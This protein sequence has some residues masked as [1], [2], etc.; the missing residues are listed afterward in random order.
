L[1][2]FASALVAYNAFAIT[3]GAVA[4]EHGRDESELL[5]HYY[6]ALEISEATDGM[7]VAIPEAR[8]DELELHSDEE[9]AAEVRTIF[10][11][12]DLS[13]YRKSIRGPKKPPPKRTNKRNSVHVSTKRILD[14][15]NKK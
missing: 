1:F 11:R 5:S 14:K 6:L 13:R 8:W 4:A 12:T 2:C 15:R 9:F 7:L 3:K 10:S